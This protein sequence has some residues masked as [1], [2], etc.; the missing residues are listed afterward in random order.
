[1][2]AISVSLCLCAV[3]KNE[4]RIFYIACL[5]LEEF[6]LSMCAVTLKLGF[7]RK[8]VVLIAISFFVFEILQK[9]RISLTVNKKDFDVVLN[10]DD[11]SDH[12]EMKFYHFLLIFSVNV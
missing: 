2:H 12:Y 1:M 9:Y 8:M 4:H 3:K 5:C 6:S 10:F 11:R 7:H